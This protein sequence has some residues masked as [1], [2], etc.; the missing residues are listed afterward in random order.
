MRLLLLILA[1]ALAAMYLTF[2]LRFGYVTL[3]PTYLFNASGE[4]SYSLQI[5]DSGQ[6]VGM[7][8]RCEGNSGTVTL[9]LVDPKGTQVAGQS[10]PA[11]KYSLN[12]M[13]EG[14][15]GIYKLHV[16]FDKFSGMLDIT[17]ARQ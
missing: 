8:G 15:P 5:Y 17:E 13:A 9:R 4:N 12:L 16:T 2:G 6:K 1:A 3:T 10:C 11:G 14:Q 7:R